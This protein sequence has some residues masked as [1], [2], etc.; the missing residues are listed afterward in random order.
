MTTD[1]MS[2][3]FAGC[4]TMNATGDGPLWSATSSQSSPSVSVSYR[5]TLNENFGESE[6]PHRPPVQGKARLSSDCK[7]LTITR[8]G[9]ETDY[10]L[11]FLESHPDLG[12]PAWRLT[13]LDGTFYD[14]ILTEHGIECTCADYNYC[15][16]N[17]Q[18][19]CKHAESARAVGLLRNDL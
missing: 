17:T 14:V 15:R 5:A 2:F 10:A 3:L 12:Y 16:V 18:K 11:E 4:A 13:K 1:G 19:K 6:M 9:K 8:S 7:T